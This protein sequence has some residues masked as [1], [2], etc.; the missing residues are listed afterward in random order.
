[1]VALPLFGNALAL[2]LTLVVVSILERLAE[3]L[4][5]LILIVVILMLEFLETCISWEAY[6]FSLD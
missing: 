1:M 3:I 2:V 4:V 6:F 5:V